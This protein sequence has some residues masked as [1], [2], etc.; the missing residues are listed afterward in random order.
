MIECGVLGRSGGES[1][2]SPVQP[3]T[4]PFAQLGGTF[5]HLYILLMRWSKVICLSSRR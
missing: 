2:V 1:V 5:A 3:I 4:V